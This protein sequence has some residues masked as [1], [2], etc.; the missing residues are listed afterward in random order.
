MKRLVLRGLMAAFCL[1][2]SANAFAADANRLVCSVSNSDRVARL[3]DPSTLEAARQ[4]Q[5]SA[6]RV[7][8]LVEGTLA[9][10]GVELH[11]PNIRDVDAPARH[12][13]LAKAVQ[14]ELRAV[15]TP[16]IAPE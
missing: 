7:L 6:Y 11:L 5:P 4:S 14:E 8:A 13:E 3:L 2:A 10:L 1:T 9:R 15:G 12:A 16:G